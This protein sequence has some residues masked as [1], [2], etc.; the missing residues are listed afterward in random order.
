MAKVPRLP[1]LFSLLALMA[2]ACMQLPSK[3]QLDAP[4]RQATLPDL[5]DYDDG[6]WVAAQ[7]L[8]LRREWL[9]EGRT[10]LPDGEMFVLPFVLTTLP[11]KNAEETKEW[12]AYVNDRYNP[13]IPW[14]YR[15][16]RR[17]GHYKCMS[18]SASTVLDW[19]A[20]DDGADLPAYR[21][22]LNGAT[23]RGF[24]HRKL[25]AL[26][27]S[28]AKDPEKKGD[29]PLLYTYTDPIEGTP[30][31]YLMVGFV[32]I[33]TLGGDDTVRPDAIFEAPDPSLPGVTHEIHVSDLPPL[34]YSVLFHDIAMSRVAADP[35]TYNQLLV[36]ALETHGPVFAGIRLRFAVSGGIVSR[37][38]IGRLSFPNVSGHGVVIVGYI[39]Q[40]GRTYFVYRE[41]FGEY[42]ELW[43]GGGPAYRVYPVHSLREAYTFQR[44]KE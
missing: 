42:D 2:A 21:S 25:D 38:D 4:P 33:M 20:L 16:E 6:A 12:V 27:Y 37:T 15:P 35:E 1:L 32:K 36:S 18:L 22:L 3:S 14:Q 23:E 17:R 13:P 26:Y 39:R 44:V 24:D 29:Y 34:R 28:L 9:K 30:I 19:Y 5:P 10:P 7:G 40:K 8:P 31:S 43:S 11:Y 41:V